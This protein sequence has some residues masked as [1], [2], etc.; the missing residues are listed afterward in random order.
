MPPS[1]AILSALRP[2]IAT[3]E[4]QAQAHAVLPTDQVMQEV[5]AVGRNLIEDDF[6]GHI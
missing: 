5:V 4:S 1:A 3:L 6:S 2:R